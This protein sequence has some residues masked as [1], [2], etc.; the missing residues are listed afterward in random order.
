M[1]ACKRYY[2]YIIMIFLLCPEVSGNRCSAAVLWINPAVSFG[3]FGFYQPRRK[4]LKTED[5][6]EIEKEKLDLD[7]APRDNQYFGPDLQ[8][9]LG[10]S[11]RGK[12]HYYGFEFGYHLL[13]LNTKTN[14][15]ISNPELSVQSGRIGLFARPNP[16]TI[17]KLGGKIQSGKSQKQKIAF[18]DD[19]EPTMRSYEFLAFAAD[20]GF[21]GSI[22]VK[23][24]RS[25][26]VYFDFLFTYSPSFLT[27]V[28]KKKI[29]LTTRL[30][31]FLI[32]LGINIPIVAK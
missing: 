5:T 30:D 2:S 17:I 10:I 31:A 9:N 8:L 7:A 32:T 3:F 16:Q 4:L 23:I 11:N 22:P 19:E 12:N 26:D 28:D 20:I 24:G 13:L 1:H 18:F 14:G 21:G 29:G 6:S 25:G 27:H 15:P